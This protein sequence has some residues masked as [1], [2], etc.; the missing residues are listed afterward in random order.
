MLRFHVLMQGVN[1]NQSIR[2]TIKSRIYTTVH[3]HADRFFQLTGLRMF[4]GLLIRIVETLI[5]RAGET[6]FL[7]ADIR[8]QNLF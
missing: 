3:K 6:I 5:A 8:H 4:N 2:T 7:V 1:V